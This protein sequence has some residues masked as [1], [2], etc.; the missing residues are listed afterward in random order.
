[1]WDAHCKRLAAPKQ[2]H[3][4]RECRPGKRCGG[5]QCPLLLGRVPHP[6]IRRFTTGLQL[7]PG[8]AMLRE[9]VAALR[10]HCQQK[11]MAEQ[12]VNGLG[13]EVNGPPSGAD[14]VALRDAAAAAETSPTFTMD[15]VFRTDRDSRAASAD[16]SKKA[17][18]MSLPQG[19][20]ISSV[21]AHYIRMH[22][23]I[24]R[25]AR[26]RNFWTSLHER[27]GKRLLRCLAP[28]SPRLSTTGSDGVCLVLGGG[29]GVGAVLQAAERKVQGDGPSVFLAGSSAIDLG[30]HARLATDNHVA[31][32]LALLPLAPEDVRLSPLSE[33]CGDSDATTA[34]PQSQN[35]SSAPAP[36]DPSALDPPTSDPSASDPAV[37]APRV[38][39][40]L[41][42]PADTLLAQN[43][44]CGLLGQ[45]LIPSLQS[46]IRN[47]LLTNG[48]T[49]FPAQARVYVA[50]ASWNTT[51]FGQQSEGFDAT[52]LNAYRWAPT[53]QAVN[54][55]REELRLLTE[56][57]VALDFDF[58]R[59]GEIRPRLR[60]LVT[61]L[62]GS[63]DGVANAAVFWFSLHSGVLP[64]ALL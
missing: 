31:A 6:H 22:S 20:T 44:D 8:N 30:V 33:G 17:G 23:E 28:E 54:T 12:M 32:N 13:G 63:S 2:W 1:M 15:L 26:T 48:A 53:Y 16:T 49:V 11:E 35:R 42:R 18:P 43:I 36:L 50:L 62:V 4:K 41:P 57:Q 29:L 61:G 27:G 40:G 24:R 10:S 21:L 52:S 47:R 59:A 55:D 56:P 60:Q 45:R 34:P 14:G 38:A 19:D 3:L 58:S 51:T 37:E 5:S 46:A 64:C 9:R 39:Q 7:Q 25:P